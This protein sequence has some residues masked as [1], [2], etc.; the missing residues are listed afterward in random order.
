[1]GH[2]ARRG[3]Y[4]GSYGL[5]VL[6]SLAGRRG[7]GVGWGGAVVCCERDTVL[8]GDTPGAL[9]TGA[10]PSIRPSICP[11]IHPSI[12]SHA[13]IQMHASVYTFLRQG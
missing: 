1:M 13:S 7:V 6:S 12:Y 4:V 10:R 9:G 3:A 11:S 8:K 2:D 5:S